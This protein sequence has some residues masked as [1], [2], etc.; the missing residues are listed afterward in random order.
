MNQESK[1]DFYHLVNK[2][3]C[4]AQIVGSYDYFWRANILHEY[5]IVSLQ[6]L[7]LLSIGLLFSYVSLTLRAFRNRCA[8]LLLTTGLPYAFLICLLSKAISLDGASEGLHE[9]FEPNVSG[10]HD[11][12]LFSKIQ[13]FILTRRSLPNKVAST[14]GIQVMDSSCKSGVFFDQLWSR[15]YNFNVFI[16]N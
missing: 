9:L 10:N 1:I 11:K 15:N 3:N 14:P 12:Q 13:E 7:L 2:T 8:L 5:D 4:Q 6:S 16:A